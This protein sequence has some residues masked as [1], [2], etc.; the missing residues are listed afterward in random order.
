MLKQK[1][2]DVVILC[3]GLGKRLRRLVPDRPK[4][5][6]EINQQPFVDILIQYISG[7]GFRHFI[8]SIGYMAGRI[9]KYY[10]HKSYLLD[11][12]FSEEKRP[13]GTGGAIKK[14]KILMRSRHFLVINGDSFCRVNLNKFLEFHHRKNALISMLLAKNKQ[15][16]D[17]GG[18]RLDNSDRIVNFNEKG[19]VKNKDLV[20]AGIYLFNRMVFSLMPKRNKFSLEYDL[21]PKMVGHRFYGYLTKGT[22][23]D[24]GTPAGLK[25]ARIYFKRMENKHFS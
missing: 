16:K 7:F 13:L 12:G 21:F 24:I 14:A 17:C 8:L 20:N 10:Q 23:I 15:N 11:I 25:R 22:L 5:M 19:R 1:D 2:I 6:V 3:G 9:R 4:A 18:V